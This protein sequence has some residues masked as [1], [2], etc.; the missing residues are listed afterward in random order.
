MVR[1]EL[2]FDAESHTYRYNGVI[3]SGVTSVLESVGLSDFSMVPHDILEQAKAFGTEVHKLTEMFDRG[4]EIPQNTS[5]LASLYLCH[6]IKF[7]SDFDVEIVEIEKRVFCKKYMYAG[8]LD[9][10]AIFRKLSQSPI[11][12]DVKT[13]E[14]SKAHQVQTSAYEYAYKTDKRQK[15]ERYTL[16][17]SNDGYKLSEAHTSR[18]DFDVFLAAL[19]VHNYKKGAK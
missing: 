16:Y 17:L 13:G 1:D 14:K 19:S 5:E 7:L 15:M 10:A 6:Y 18:K 12:F 4:E 11:I 9:R 2:V 8:T 3:V